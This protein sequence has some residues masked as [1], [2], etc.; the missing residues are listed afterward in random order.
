MVERGTDG[1][2]EAPAELVEQG[3]GMGERD[4]HDGDDSGEELGKE[5]ENMPGS[6]CADA[7]EASVNWP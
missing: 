5:G 3:L 1:N 6:L 7:S 4:L 2:S